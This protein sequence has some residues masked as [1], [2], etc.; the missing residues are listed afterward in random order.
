MKNLTKLALSL[1]AVGALT[2]C[3][4]GTKVSEEK[5]Q[6]KINAIEAHEYS[7][8][9]VSYSINMT[10]TG[11]YKS[12]KASGKIEFTYDKDAKM[13]TTESSDDHALE[14][15]S[16]I[17]T[18][19]GQKI[20]SYKPDS[21]DIKYTTTYYVNPL[22]VVVKVKGTSKGDYSTVKMDQTV[23]SQ[24]DKYGYTTKYTTKYNNSF[25]YGTSGVSV[26][27]TQKGTESYTISYK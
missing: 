16:Y 8:A 18:I 25:E 2:G 27:G 3:F 20:S 6:E 11:T 26:S 22:K 17:M 15:R 21:S 23:T 12:E 10:G 7:K 5:F 19:R 1:V 4:G 9:V 13:W 14:C 24:F